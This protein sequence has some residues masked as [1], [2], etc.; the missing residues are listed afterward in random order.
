[1]PHIISLF[2]TAISFVQLHL[3]SSYITG[4]VPHQRQIRWLKQM[5]TNICTKTPG[6]LSTQEISQGHELMYAWSHLD[7]CNK[8]TALAVESLMKRVIDE[9]RAGNDKAETTVE[10]YNCL[11]EGWAR[12]NCGVAAAERCEQILHQMQDL[13]PAPNLSSFKVAL[14]AW[15]QAKDCNYAPHRAQRVLEWMIR[16]VKTQ[17]N[18]Q[19][20]PD[21]DCFDI[22]LQTLSNSGL[23]DAP[24]KAE[25]LLGAMERLYEE[26]GRQQLKPRTTSFNAVLSAWCRSPR[27]YALDRAADVLSFMELLEARGDAT[28]APDRASYSIVMGALTKSSKDKALAAHKADIFLQHVESGY[29]EGKRKLA[30]DTYMYNTAMGCWAKANVSGAYKHARAILDRQVALYATGGCT[31]CKPDVYGFTSVIAG[32][33]A[34]TGHKKDKLLAFDVALQTY[35]ELQ[36]SCEQPNH[37]TYGTMLKACCKLLPISSPIRQQLTREIFQSACSDGCVGDMTI[38]R[39]RE[40]A[41]PECYRELI[42][43]HSRR[44]L[45][46]AWTRNVHEKNEFRVKRSTAK[47]Q[48]AEV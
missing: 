11:L 13:G 29:Y 42:Q 2:V 5:T 37:V 46:D 27:P 9:Q 32:C 28:V 33:A 47:R 7:S 10:D 1:M 18:L 38:S 25:K 3:G 14:M 43:G 41:T 23:K 17:E 16:L 40:A 21:S 6:H 30:P 12:A 8:E 36:A 39:F 15:R 20:L 22:V 31:R 48:S 44:H 34:E 26:T 4:A 19:V 24:K 45:P 35:R